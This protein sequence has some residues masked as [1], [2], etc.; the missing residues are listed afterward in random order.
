L[1]LDTPEG[2][3]HSHGV[4]ND[5][6]ENKRP[7]DGRDAAMKKK[8]AKTDLNR[9]HRRFGQ[10]ESAANRIAARLEATGEYDGVDRMIERQPLAHREFLA[11]FAA[12][13]GSVP[14]VPD[15]AR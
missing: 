11:G 8:K 14:P 6:D 12:G 1:V 5:P 13:Y 15:V 10:C 9:M 4:G 2:V 3:W 7:D